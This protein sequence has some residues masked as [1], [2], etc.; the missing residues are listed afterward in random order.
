MKQLFENKERPLYGSA[1]PMRLGRLGDSDVAQYVSARFA[2]TGRSVGETLNPLVQTAQGHPQRTI[3]LAYHVWETVEQ[4]KSGTLRDW[5]A[6]HASA[7]A[8]VK[9]EFEAMWRGYG[10]SVD[11]K[12]LRSIVAGDG[13]AYRVRILERLDLEKST[14]SAAVERLLAIADIEPTGK[15]K[16]QIVDPLYAEW[17]AKLDTGADEALDDA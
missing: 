11:Q 8:E 1:V 5:H 3:M 12:T 14:A 2:A 16:Y 10:S 15:G 13:S 6:A 4:G 17:I 9:P 7:L